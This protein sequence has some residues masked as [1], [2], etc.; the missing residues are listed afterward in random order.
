MLSSTPA[1]V[2]SLVGVSVE[3]GTFGGILIGLMC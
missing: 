3:L 2:F 1:G